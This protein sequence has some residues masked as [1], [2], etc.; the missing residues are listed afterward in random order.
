LKKKIHVADVKPGMFIHEICANWL[1]H[2]FWKGAFALDSTDGLKKLERSGIKEV[3]ID[4]DRGLDVESHTPVQ[5]QEDEKQLIDN[6][7]HEAIAEPPKIEPRMVMDEEMSGARKLLA[8]SRKT[9]VSMFHETRMGHALGLEEAGA[10]ANEINESISHNPNALISLVRLKN[11][12]EYTYMHSIAVCALM[13]ALGRQLDIK[14]KEL[15]H[16]GMAG[17]F[18]DIGKVMIPETVL[19]KPGT[20]TEVE[21]ATMKQHP[22]LGWNMLKKLPGIDDAILDVCLRHHERTDGTGY[23]HQP[24]GEALSLG[25]RMAA[26]CDVYDAITSDR[27]YKSAWEPSEAIRKM[28]SWQNGHFDLKVFHAFVKT[29]GIYPVGTLIRLKS[30]HM[31]VVIDQTEKSLATPIVKVFFSLKSNSHIRPET[32]NLSQSDDCIES[33]EDP[34]QWSFDLPSIME[35]LS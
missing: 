34:G 3:W 24:S 13:T 14:G 10:V 15:H 7:L 16:L 18:H 5:T 20:L 32:I 21:F 26:V 23:P 30:G 31:G 19:N 17:L 27:C 9:L 11:K 8:A 35:T 6:V 12:N 25:A 28:A 29:V 4:T 22:A 33:S 1:D 2:A